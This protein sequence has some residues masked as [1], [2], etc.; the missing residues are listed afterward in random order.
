MKS[1]TRKTLLLAMTCAL[2]V[3]AQGTFAQSRLPNPMLVFLG[4]R[5]RRRCRQRSDSLHVRRI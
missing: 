1:F 2:M 3:A 5:T 4:S